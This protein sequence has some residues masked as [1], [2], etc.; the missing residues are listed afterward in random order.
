MF[1]DNACEKQFKKQIIMITEI[2]KRQIAI[3]LELQENINQPLIQLYKSMILM[4][5]PNLEN[6]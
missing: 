1:L 3:V 5:V 6:Y 4:S 2:H